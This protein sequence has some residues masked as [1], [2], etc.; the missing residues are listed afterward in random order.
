MKQAEKEKKN[1]VLNSVHTRLGQE[2]SEK[3]RKRNQK[4]KKVNSGII[5]IQTGKRQAEKEKKNLVPNSVPTLPM[6]EN[7]KKKAKKLKKLKNIIPA[8]F[9]S[10]PG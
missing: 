10:K 5:S 8:L 2:S 7:S 4:I 3:N 6:Q 9:L 1:L